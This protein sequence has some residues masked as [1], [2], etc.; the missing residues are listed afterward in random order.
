MV[1]V[2]HI[3][4]GDLWA[5][6]EVMAY[7][8]M[9]GLKAYDDLALSAILLNEGRL[10]EELHKLGIMVHL[11]DES[12]T[13]LFHILLGIRQILSKRPPDVIHSHRYKENILAYLISKSIHGPKLIGTQH[14]MPEVYGG[15]TGLKHQLIT[16]LNFF[17]LSRSFHQAVAVSR[18]MQNAFVK[19]YGFDKMKV[20][21]IHNGID[22]P[23]IS[24]KR[25]NVCP[26]VIGSSGRL[27]S[28]KD[29]PFMVEIAKA[30][31]EKTSRVSFNLAGDG[32]ERPKLHTLIQQYALN[33][34]F[35]LK[36]HLKDMSAFY[37]GLD[38]YLNTS[39]HEGIP[40]SVLEAMA[41]GLPVI[42]P[43]VGGFPEIIDD[44]VDGYLLNERDPR[45][46]AEKCLVLH[47]NKEM[48]Q[49][50]SQAARQKVVRE[51][52]M[53]NMA[54][55]YYNLYLKVINNR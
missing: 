50:M 1:R 19:Q 29:Y 31:R 25:Y 15:E 46:F 26:F 35:V 34:I 53:E 21:V 12:K 51:F 10:A 3:I 11:V 41:H 36:G 16:K 23:K 2:C 47:E 13:S 49:Q 24:T 27:F 38:L 20:S 18:D 45:D 43:K 55:Q 4:S 37:Q 30:I 7:H 14:G 42:A 5:G 52:S 32:P 17:L 6:A 44:G 8:L 33:G 48:W 54:R 9:K 22:V 39:I 40:M 28:V